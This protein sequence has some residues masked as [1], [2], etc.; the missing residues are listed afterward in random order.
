MATPPN[1]LSNEYV[2]DTMGLILYIERRRMPFRLKALFM[3]VESGKGHLYIPG[4]VFAE[5]LYLSEKQRIR[6]SVQSVHDLMLRYEAFKEYPLSYEV[7][8]AATV[9]GEIP[10]LHD[11]LI[12]ATACLL[13]CPL[14]TNDPVLQGCKAISTIWD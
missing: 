9:L 4:I 6:T 7:I 12:A 11:R 2:T 14:I 13:H 8:Q 3:A 5:I 10:E 1:T